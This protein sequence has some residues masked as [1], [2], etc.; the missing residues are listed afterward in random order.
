MYAATND[1]VPCG[2]FFFVLSTADYRHEVSFVSSTAIAA[3]LVVVDVVV[4]AAVVVVVVGG[5]V[6]VFAS[7]SL[8]L[9]C[10]VDSDC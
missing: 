9:T 7:M 1:K 4:V 10:L 3:V 5:G 6:V 8:F 2:S